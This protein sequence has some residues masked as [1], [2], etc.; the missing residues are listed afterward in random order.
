MRKGDDREFANAA[1]NTVD[2]KTFGTTNTN[3]KVLC[4]FFDYS[5]M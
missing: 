2:I 5:L 1:M 4:R 3:I